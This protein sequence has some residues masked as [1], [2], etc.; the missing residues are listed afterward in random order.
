MISNF[1]IIY[2]LRLYLIKF[3]E[4]S[5]TKIYWKCVYYDEKPIVAV[6]WYNIQKE[7][8]NIENKNDDFYMIIFHIESFDRN[9]NK[10]N[11]YINI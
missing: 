6:I 11:L 2:N 10:I 1:Y 7:R 8:K 9:G 3:N 5:Y 4:Y